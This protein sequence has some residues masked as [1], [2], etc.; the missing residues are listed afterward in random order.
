MTPEQIKKLEDLERRIAEM[1]AYISDKK[2]QQ[3]SL[4]LDPASVRV[5]GKALQDA[6]YSL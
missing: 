1:E 4:P 3:I 5:V 2:E 6:N